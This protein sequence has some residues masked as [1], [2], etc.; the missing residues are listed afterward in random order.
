MTERGIERQRVTEKG[1][2]R[3]LETES[4]CACVNERVRVCAY[5]YPG[6]VCATVRRVPAKSGTLQGSEKDDI[7]L[8][9]P[10]SPKPYSGWRKVDMRLPGK[11]NSNFHGAR[12]VYHN[13]FD[14]EV[15]SDQ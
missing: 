6:V 9:Q 13:H 8:C 1:T 12:P 15:D 10:Q 11:V 4:V 14:E 7:V 5:V 2:E 3:H